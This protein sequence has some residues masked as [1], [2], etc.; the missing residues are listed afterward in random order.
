VKITTQEEYHDKKE[1]LRN[2]DVEIAEFHRKIQIQKD[3]KVQ[4]RKELEEIRLKLQ[5]EFAEIMKK[6]K[7]KK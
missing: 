3:Y 4:Y 5:K 7:K 1:R 2:C 6:P